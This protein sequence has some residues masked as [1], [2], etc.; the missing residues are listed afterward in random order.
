MLYECDVY[1]GAIAQQKQKLSTLMCY[2]YYYSATSQYYVRRCSLL[3]Q[4]KYHGL[5]FTLSALTLLV[6]WQE[7]H[8][9]YK[10]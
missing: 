3:L 8:P 1:V 7:G 2:Y 4:T 5:S 6:G 9:A 10:N